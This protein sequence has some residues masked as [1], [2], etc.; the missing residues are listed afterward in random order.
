MA[1]T[2]AG[3]T[4]D[5]PFVGKANAATRRYERTA[6]MKFDDMKSRKRI[7]RKSLGICLGMALGA[8][9]TAVTEAAAQQP[10]HVDPAISGSRDG[11][12]REGRNRSAPPPVQG[13]GAIPRPPAGP[14]AGVPPVPEFRSYDGSGNNVQHPLWGT[15]GVNYLRERS[16]AFYADGKS[17]PAGANRPSARVISNAVAAQGD[18]STADERGLSTCLY[19]FGQ[20]LDHD[21]GLAAGGFSEA[22]DISVPA[23]DPW[24]DPASTGT[25]KI[26]MDRSAF[27]PATGTSNPREQ[28]NTVTSFIDGSQIYGVDR[29]RA[30][31]LRAG[32]SGKLKVRATEFGDMLP[33]NDGTLANDDPLGN[34]VTSLV[35]AGDV[36][37]NEQPGLTTFHTVFLREH[38]M[39][40]GRIATRHREWDDERIF[41]EARRIVIAELQAIVN[42]EF[43]PALLGRPL[44]RYAGYRP[45]VNPGL[46]NVFAAAAYRNGHSMVGPDIGVI[47]EHFVEIDSLPLQSVFFNPGVIASVQGIDPFVRYFAVD[48]QQLNDTMI[49]DPLRNFLFGPPGAGGFDL[50]ALNIQRGRDHGLPDY[51]TVRRDFGLKPVRSFAQITSNVSV[52]ASLASLYKDVNN[53]DAWVGMLAEDHLPGSSLGATHNAVLRAQFMAL[54]DGDRFWYQNFAFNPQQLGEIERTRL[55]DILMRNTSVTGLQPRVFFAEDLSAP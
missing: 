25:K 20:F 29:A 37:A 52:A 18:V 6:I 36:R 50:G 1:R 4:I 10:P 9:A 19:E 53:V 26:W 42:N 2:T 46:S 55:S 35:V 51:N 27:N 8:I 15:P 31:W 32:T 48:T 40:A 54:R 3:C 41:Q 47:D 43:L 45:N 23:G 34:P 14:G 30:A 17:A 5:E 49:V 38:N 7:V 13:Q 12:R 16:G 33:L 22:F 21:I 11:W 24:F 44:P 28:L 39:Q